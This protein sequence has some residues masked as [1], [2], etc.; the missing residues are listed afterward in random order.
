MDYA[1]LIEL[2]GFDIIF[3]GLLTILTCYV[4]REL[5]TAP[6]SSDCLKA[7]NG[8]WEK[9]KSYLQ[10][11]IEETEDCQPPG[12]STTRPPRAAQLIGMLLMASLLGMVINI[13]GDR[14]LD[15]DMFVRNIPFVWP[16]F[17]E[18][19]QTKTTALRW[20][21]CVTWH[22]ENAIK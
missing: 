3:L 22:P 4:G 6:R 5:W 1:A 7:F 18:N 17:R 12:S 2:V 8:G 15:N 19:K 10:G 16:E 14:L 20:W 9:Y 11:C 21:P 13:V